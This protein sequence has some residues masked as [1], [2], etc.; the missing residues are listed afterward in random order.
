MITGGGGRRGVFV[1]KKILSKRRGRSRNEGYKK[2]K[3]N[4]NLTYV[5]VHMI[6]TYVVRR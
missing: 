5:H 6:H 1:F 3:T 4:P 2:S